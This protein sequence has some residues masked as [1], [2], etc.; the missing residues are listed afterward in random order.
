MFE[1][2]TYD[3]LL[4]RVQDLEKLGM[5]AI[6]PVN[7]KCK[8]DTPIMTD[9]LIENVIEILEKKP[10]LQGSFFKRTRCAI[11]SHVFVCTGDTSPH[12]RKTYQSI[13]GTC[14]G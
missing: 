7:I 2:P 9:R 1:K 5:A 10:L 4:K 8:L 13:P 14:C 11:Q 3:E 12:L 6:D